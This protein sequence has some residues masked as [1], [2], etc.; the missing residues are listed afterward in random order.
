MVVVHILAFLAGAAVVVLTVRSAI[1]TFLVPRALQAYLARFVYDT[2][3][4]VFWFR[5]NH[6]HDYEHR[7]RVMA[8]YSPVSLLGLLGPG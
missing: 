6:R 8:Y 1:R 4:R 5:A 2:V 7:D 3:R